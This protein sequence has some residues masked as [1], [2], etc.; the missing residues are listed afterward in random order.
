MRIGFRSLRWRL[1]AGGLLAVGIPLLAFASLLVSMLWSFYLQQ[2]QHELNGKAYIIADAAAP[3]LSP[4]TPEDPEAL[5]RMVDQWRIHSEVRV[6]VADARGILVAAPLQGDVGS[7]VDDSR[8]P[9]LREALAGRANSMVWRNPQ[10]GNQDTMYVNVPVREENR[11]LGAVRVAY[12][13]TQIQQNIGRIRAALLSAVT[14]YAALIVVL[15]FWLAGTIVRP[16]EALSRSAQRLAAGELEHRVKVEATE[17][18]IH[19]GA[20]L[21]QMA[22]RLQHLE[23][24]RRRYVSDVSH[25]LRTPLASIRGLAET[26]L[27]Y[28]PSDP[29][30]PGRY[31]PRIIGQTDRLARL[32]SQ[33]L[34]ISQ[35][36]S[37]TLV[38][39]VQPLSLAPLVEEVVQ[40]CAADADGREVRL[41]VDIPRDFPDVTADRDRLV[42]VLT[43][44]IDNGIRHT[45]PGGRLTIRAEAMGDTV[46]LTG[47][48]TGKGIPPEH[49]P[50]VF[51]RFYRVDPARSRG[52]GGAGLGLAIVQ[53]IVR[54][55]GG[56]VR[57][58]SEV[59]QG[60]RFTIDLPLTR[61]DGSA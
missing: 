17:E 57:V 38:T 51:T 28:G 21:N 54:A 11:V 7:P 15:T 52:S 1:I 42:Q 19:L 45:P 39:S 53:E 49:L 6:T 8:R 23:G 13:L 22:E 9:G 5:S 29:E 26:L 16:V 58:D 34:D 50:H 47:E 60:T 48:D 36:E 56:R 30:L 44:L 10:Y 2:L 12:T 55:H 32:A 14:G 59:G 20:T 31:L 4:S 41:V 3:I 37:G 25:E 24:L 46:T 61:P 27:E 35:I 40:G 43:N 18:I 33:L